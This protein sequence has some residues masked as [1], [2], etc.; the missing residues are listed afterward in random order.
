MIL[1]LQALTLGHYWIKGINCFGSGRKID[2]IFEP[3]AWIT[4]PD[5]MG[6][7]HRVGS[8]RA[9]VIAFSLAIRRGNYRFRLLT[10][11]CQE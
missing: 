9:L 2:R 10:A 4:D 5:P 11:N 3:A 8:V 7:K 6:S 1:T